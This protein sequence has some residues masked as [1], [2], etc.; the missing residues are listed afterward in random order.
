MS[1]EGHRCRARGL[2]WPPAARGRGRG[3]KVTHVSTSRRPQ[4]HGRGLAHL[5]G[6]KQSLCVSFGNS[7]C[8]GGSSLGRRVRILQKLFH[9]HFI[10]FPT[11]NAS[12]LSLWRFGAGKAFCLPF[13]P[14]VGCADES[15]ETHKPSVCCTQTRFYIERQQLPK[16]FGC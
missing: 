8:T 11:V 10:S 2:S 4:Q 6:R 1:Q 13:R 5:S 3:A 9:S 7:V 14:C 15:T 12:L 16:E